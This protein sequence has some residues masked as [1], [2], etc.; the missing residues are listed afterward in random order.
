MHHRSNRQ[1]NEE[2][3]SMIERAIA[4]DPNYAH[5]HAHAGKACISA[6][7]RG[8]GW[9]ED[10]EAKWNV[11]VSELQISL[12][13]DDNDRDVHR[14]L[15]A[16]SITR[17]E[18]DKAVF[19]QDRALSLNSND[20]LIV[21]QKGELLAWLGWAGPRTELSGSRKRCA[22]THTIPSEFG[23]IW[24]APILSPVDIRRP[25]PPFT[26]SVRPI[27]ATTRSSQPRT[28][29]WA[30]KPR[31]ARMSPRRWRSN[32]T[33]QS[34]SISRRCATR[35]MKNATIIAMRY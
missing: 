27:T 28:V 21:V 29:K 7:A 15:A 22:S 3:L 25:L 10:M 18:F 8:Y 31:P 32:P 5:A 30:T 20:D 12:A 11:V 35:A 9:V 6:Q 26:K 24:V 33:F 1:S 19:H 23:T 16:V 17:R 34:P 13:L 4:I 2:A 14:I